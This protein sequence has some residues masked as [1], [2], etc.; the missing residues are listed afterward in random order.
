[1]VVLVTLL[2]LF[3]CFIALSRIRDMPTLVPVPL[4]LTFG[5]MLLSGPACCNYVSC[6]FC[7]RV[8]RG[9][10]SNQEADQKAS[11]EANQE[12]QMEEV[13]QESQPSPPSR[14]QRRFTLGEHE[15]REETHWDKG[16]SEQILEPREPKF[17]DGVYSL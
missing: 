1:M 15:L 17:A 7:F 4:N 13:T 12:S 10:S 3:G 14:S 8:H 11:R 9:P 16:D 5:L 2:F 6:W